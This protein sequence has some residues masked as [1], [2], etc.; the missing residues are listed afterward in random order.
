MQP[1]SRIGNAG[2]WL[3]RARRLGQALRRWTAAS[4]FPRHPRHA[5]KRPGRQATDGAEGLAVSDQGLGLLQQMLP[6]S[7]FGLRTEANI[8]VVA[9]WFLKSLD[10]PGD[11]C[12]FGCFRGTMSIKFAYALK[13]L[14][15]DKTIFAF[16]TFEG[17]QIA[18]P[19]GGALGIGAYSDNHNAFEEL[20]RWGAAIPVRPVKGDARETCKLL[21]NTLSFVWLDIDFD[22]LME[23]VLD[24]IWPLL[25]PGTIIGID[26]VGRPETPSVAPW[27][28]RITKEGKL[29]ELARYPGDFIRFFHAN[30]AK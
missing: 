28:D 29:I 18:D 16:D 21:K 27:V 12:E 14:G 20:T 24:A 2:L 13:V 6:A 19:A 22:I 9:P 8:G 7:V 23:P 30:L 4:G 17:F 25:T 1:C 15:R 3:R 5:N 26:D 11:A 10:I